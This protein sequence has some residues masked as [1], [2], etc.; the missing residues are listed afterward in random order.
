MKSF[1]WSVIICASIGGGAA[2]M[3]ASQSGDGAKA[4]HHRT[5]FSHLTSAVWRHGQSFEKNDLTAVPNNN[6]NP[7][8]QPHRDRPERLAL[9]KSGTKF[10]VTLAG[11][12]A[13][14]GHEVAVV[15]VKT[16]K[17]IK[18]I[19]VGR[20]P[21][22]PVLH[23]DGR[24][25]VVINE[26][27]NYATVIDT[28]TDKA[29]GEIPLDYYC[30]G[31]VFAE[32]GKRAWVANRYLD[33]VLVVEINATVDSFTGKIREV[34]GFDEN[35]FY[36]DKSISPALNKELLHRGFTQ[37][38]I[39]KSLRR[40]VGGIN[41]ILRARCSRCHSEPA[42]GYLCGPDRVENFL[43]AVECSIG[44]RPYASMLL[45][46]VLPQSLKGF[47]DQQVTPEIHAGGAL[48]E[49]GEPDLLRVVDWIRKAE[50]G[51]GIPVG[52]HQSHPKDL[53]LS[54]DGRHL[55]VGN[56]GTMD[57]S[58]IDVE[59]EHEVGGILI[60]NVA[61][62]VAIVPDPEGKHPQLIA[63]TMGAGFGAPNAR[64][65]HGGE[66]WDPEHPEAQFTVL[67]DPV[68]TDAY[69]IDQQAVMGPFDAIDGTWNFKMR[70]IQNDVVAIDLS[71]L[72][73]PKWKPG[74][75]LDYLLHANVYESHP[76][77][78]RYTSDTVEATTGD[79]K[80][81]I[82]PELQRVH[83][84]FAEWAAVVGDRMYVTM[85]GTFEVVEWKVQP[86]ASDP[87][88]K[89]V[90]L[91]VFETGLRPVG[92]VAGRPN[93]PSA[94][95]LFVANQLGE[96]VSIIDLK[97]GDG[98][99]IKVGDLEAP[100]LATDAEKGELI[101]HT[102]VFASDGD[103]SCLH[104]H[105]RDT[106]DGRAWGAAETVGQ[107]REGHLTPGG[108]LGI[109]QMRN[110]FAIQ[111]Y[112]FEGT[113]RL[114]EGQGADIAEP[115]SSIDF[116]RPVWVGD[117]THVQSPVP[118]D[119]RRLMHEEIKER[120]EIRKLGDQWYDL[121]ERRE[122]FFKQQTKRYMGEKYGLRNMFRF[123]GSWLGNTTHLMPNPYDQENAS[124]VRGR[125]LFN[126][127][128]VMC[129]VCHT[130]P[131]FTNKDL[132][133][134]NNDRRALPQLTTV[135]RRDASYTLAS[136][137]IVDIANGITDFEMEPDDPG[138]VEDVEG[139]FTTMQLR[140]IFD[141]P[142][143]FL[144]HARARS[145]REV[146]CT[147]G[148]PALRQYRYPV[149]QGGEVVRPNRYEIGFNETTARTT[150][151]PLNPEDQV[152]DTHGGTSQLTPQQIDDLMNFMLS[153][154]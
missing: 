78:V 150:E 142:P 82:P 117:F 136:V 140:G 135:T 55:F 92:I 17:V 131:E 104:C 98:D 107:D 18:R 125:S 123:V 79:I 128:S 1:Y 99:E 62:H 60:Q 39:N 24:F 44:G 30:Q 19:G 100:A 23:P 133:L 110:I 46:A 93:T 15:D 51:P 147:P 64:D 120:V 103:T 137:R 26:L 5:R 153:I 34:G 96:T 54:P 67:R 97:T 105:Y 129:S 22:V 118:K 89:L 113:H 111:P 122:E 16:R 130:A 21:Y 37:E 109:P 108:T 90:P 45:R 63:L 149:L 115:A 33:Q 119:Q 139:S 146:L 58:V 134:T 13:E 2:L 40:G 20:R 77:W 27:S 91:R 88:E 68:T 127:S 8:P 61:S 152:F 66:T 25:L 75:Q 32:D 95:K 56:T 154:E 29:V 84:A 112:Y 57:I 43:S 49:P 47:G 132:A 94:D 41:G 126:D 14:P 71:R 53:V 7:E 31:L 50:G 28:R 3:G 69:P 116:D 138:R 11:T 124:V 73:I 141:R 59:A 36:G 85:A 151:G 81:D 87:S 148:H 102:S 9:D 38:Q 80:G 4:K 145:L 76:D 70:D 42:G 72:K 52:N 143:V 83:G 121:E 6:P 10:Y 74:M 48:F 35:E 114:S 106:G 86:N 144:H 12:E 101:V 65:P